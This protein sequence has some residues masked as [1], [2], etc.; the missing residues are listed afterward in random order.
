MKNNPTTLTGHGT[1]PR[2]LT[3]SLDAVLRRCMLALI[4][5]ALAPLTS[6]GPARAFAQTPAATPTPSEEELRLQEEKQLLVLQKE[7]EEAKKAI[8]EAQPKPSATPLEGNT[9]LDAN[10]RIETDMVS[11]KALSAA[12]DNISKEIICVAHGKK[13][14]QT[15]DCQYAAT[16]QKKNVKIAIYDAQVIKDWRFYQAL[17]P[18]FK[19]QIKDLRATYIRLLCKDT[20]DETFKTNYCT[21]AA[22]AREDPETLGLPLVPSSVIPSA[23]AA[24]T[25]VLKSFIDLVA[26]FRTDT[27]IE[28]RSVTID[29]TALVAETFRALKNDYGAERDRLTL[30]YPEMLPPRLVSGTK[31]SETLTIVGELYLFKAEADKII[32]SKN[33]ER[34]RKLNSIKEKV[35]ARDKLKAELEQVNELLRKIENL[36]TAKKFEKDETAVKRLH[37]E[38]VKT[39]VEMS[40][41]GHPAVLAAEIGRLE[42]DIKPVE[43]EA[44][45]L[46]KDAKTL[47]DLN[48][49]FQ[50]FVTQFIKVDANGINALALFVKSEDIDKVLEGPDS[51]WLEIKSVS[52]GGNNRIRK[53]LL[54]YFT[55]AKVDHSGGIIV[56]YTL[57]DKSGAVLYSD[58]LSFYEGYVEPKKIRSKDRVADFAD[59]V[60]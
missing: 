28:G 6:W 49:A 29:E 32:K 45:Q 9:T 15:T 13:K 53:N 59:K 18:A 16:E 3:A 57:Y 48:E 30:Y 4:L 42:K 52:A 40:K 23:F 27:K 51:Y 5:M 8:R 56:E 21:P 26:L 60:Q 20:K 11:Y 25:S 55:G 1:A 58:K 17:S 43:D 31:E 46:A 22:A 47:S 12:S 54:R 33:D 35:P 41:F 2:V 7:I 10:V 44:K 24:G 50:N 37:A 39:R 34:E 38:I 14:G 19:G 36:E